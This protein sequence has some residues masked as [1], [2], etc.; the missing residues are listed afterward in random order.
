[1]VRACVTIDTMIPASMTPS[2]HAGDQNGKLLSMHN[3][4]DCRKP[5]APRHVAQLQRLPHHGAE[6]PFRA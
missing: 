3:F 4:A 1:V 2:L 6:S 5:C